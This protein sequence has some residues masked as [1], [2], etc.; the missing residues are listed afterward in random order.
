[1]VKY[2]IAKTSQGK[3]PAWIA[4]V[5]QIPGY[6]SAPSSGGLGSAVNRLVSV[7]FVKI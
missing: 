1:V 5:K 6:G 2:G 4:I 3:I 7:V